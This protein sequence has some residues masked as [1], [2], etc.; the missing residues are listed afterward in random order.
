MH[1]FLLGHVGRQH[2]GADGFRRQLVRALTG[3]FVVVDADDDCRLTAA[4]AFLRDRFARVPA[5]EPQVGVLE[6]VLSVG[7]VDDGKGFALLVGRDIDAHTLVAERIGQRQGCDLLL[8]HPFTPP[9]GMI[10]C[11]LQ[12]SI[13]GC[14]N[15]SL[16]VLSTGTASVTVTVSSDT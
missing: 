6:Q 1:P 12:Y 16:C 5:A 8:N 9:F 3:A 15:Q 7:H 2:H 14:K 13:S 11:Y 10:I 4:A